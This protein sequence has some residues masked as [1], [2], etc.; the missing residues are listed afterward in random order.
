MFKS[1]SIHR[2]IQPVDFPAIVMLGTSAACNLKGCP[3][4]F[5][6]PSDPNIETNHGKFLNAELRERSGKSA[7]EN[8][9]FRGPQWIGGFFVYR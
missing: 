6:E 8:L 9:G 7:P 3:I 5:F 2:R 4:Y 1:G